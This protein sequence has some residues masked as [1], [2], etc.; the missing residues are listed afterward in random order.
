[1][2][3]AA[4]DVR[5]ADGSETIW[6]SAADNV[7]LDQDFGDAAKVQAAF[8]QA[9]LVVE[10]T[11][12]NQRIANCQMEPRSGVASYDAATESYTLISGNQ[13][14]HAPRTSCWRKAG[15]WP[16]EKIRFVCPDVSGGF[17]PAAMIST[18]SRPHHPVGERRSASSGR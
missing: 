3:Q 16:L 17:E 4:T 18:P 11:F 7:A 1:M 13:G 10:Q 2:L 12:V 6:P 5:R 8:E 15:A 14:V 9:D